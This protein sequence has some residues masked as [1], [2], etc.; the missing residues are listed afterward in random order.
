MVFEAPRLGCEKVL[1]PMAA[2]SYLM[3]M[4]KSPSFPKLPLAGLKMVIE[5]LEGL[6]KL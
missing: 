6:P 1:T 2:F 5:K 4:P 3:D